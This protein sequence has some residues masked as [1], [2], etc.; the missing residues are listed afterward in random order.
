MFLY[1]AVS[2]GNVVPGMICG[3]MSSRCSFSTVANFVQPDCL[4]GLIGLVVTVPLSV[5]QKLI[6]Q[7]LKAFLTNSE[8]KPTILTIS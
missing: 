6:P 4:E 8:N 2:S 5:A 1:A 3:M 7:M